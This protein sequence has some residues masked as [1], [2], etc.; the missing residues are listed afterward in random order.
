MPHYK[1][2][3][4]AMAGDLIRGRGYNQTKEKGCIGIATDVRPGTICNLTVAYLKMVPADKVEVASHSV[5][6]LDVVTERGPQG[7]VLKTR[8]MALVAETDDGQ[9]DDFELIRRE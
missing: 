9:T 7:E 5:R 2:G 3:T 4:P 8:A 1:D 6:L